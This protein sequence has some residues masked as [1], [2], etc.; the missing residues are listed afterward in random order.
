MIR[1]QLLA[2]RNGA[3]SPNLRNI[4]LEV[5]VSFSYNGSSHAVMM[6]SPQDLQDFAVGFSLTQR[7]VERSS[8]I[9]AIEIVALAKGID[10]QLWISPD[11]AANI[12][13]KRRALAG[14]TGC[15]ICGVEGID[16]A[17]QPVQ[18][19]DTTI[20]V[21][22]TEIHTAMSALSAN[23]PLGMAT[24]ATHAAGYWS[25]ETGLMA[26]RED[27]GRHNAL[28]KL[29]GALAQR[30]DMH[31][32]IV[33]LTSRVSIEMVQ[34]TAAIGASMIIAVSAPTSL[35]IETAEAANIGLIGV[36][37]DDGFEVFTYPERI[38]ES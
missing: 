35:A 19:V 21:L 9:E 11:K 32:G 25:R 23:Q 14:P 37:R 1:R 7:I 15:G 22:A 24:R 2:F 26:V 6:A 5:P 28:D 20:T 12:A 34:K 30:A 3:V 33:L 29:A 38:V 13:K 17:V 10:C 16:A 31:N 4:P 18:R 27:V 8:D 36:A